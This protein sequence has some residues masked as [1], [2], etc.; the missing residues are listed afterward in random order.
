MITITQTV[1]CKHPWCRAKISTTGSI[2]EA[3]KI[4]NKDQYHL[5]AIYAQQNQVSPWEKSD[6]L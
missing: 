4:H 2:S 5:D 3:L 6:E 1:E